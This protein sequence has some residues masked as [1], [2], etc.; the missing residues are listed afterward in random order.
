MSINM[1]ALRQMAER[2]AG[3]VE[4]MTLIILMTALLALLLVA[5]VKR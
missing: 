2:G 4:G 1:E 3:G 5:V